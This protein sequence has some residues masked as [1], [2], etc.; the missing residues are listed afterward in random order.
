[1]N[2]EDSPFGDWFEPFTGP[3]SKSDLLVHLQ[4]LSRFVTGL[5][6]Q[7]SLADTL[8]PLCQQVM[9]ATGG[10]ACAV[11]LADS[12]DVLAHFQ[13]AATVGLP[14]EGVALFEKIM[15]SGLP[16]PPLQ[17]YQSR[18]MQI[19]RDMKGLAQRLLRHEHP[20]FQRLAQV[21][22]EQ[23]WEVGVVVPILRGPHILGLLLAYFERE[24]SLDEEALVFLKTL[25]ELAGAAIESC[26]LAQIA[27]ERGA[28]QERQR[29]AMELHDS[30]SQGLYALGLGVRTAQRHLDT[31]PV[32]AKEE[33]VYLNSLVEGAQLEM[34][35]LLHALQPEGLENQGLAGALKGQAELLQLRHG[36]E[37]HSQLTEPEGLQENARL[38]LFRVGLEALRNVV[39]HANASRVRLRLERTGPDLELEVCDDGLG[40]DP[41]EEHPQRLGLKV[42]R[43]RMLAVGGNLWVQSKPGQGTHILAR[44]PW[45][46]QFALEEPSV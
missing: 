39:S 7:R 24:D 27:Q 35:A 36:I 14:A 40:F 9:E 46:L 37:I 8:M 33:L 12:R 29:L 44:L 18:Q 30:V 6:L 38:A 26:R 41:A 17:A 11:V 25:S 22:L 45:P 34:R 1:M 13:V 32:Q 19:G 42:M 3:H 10:T 23:A 2:F 28:L 16:F 43:E 5:S 20:L 15:S 31:D 4:R 21:T